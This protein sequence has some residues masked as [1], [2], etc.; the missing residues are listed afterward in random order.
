VANID[1]I[2]PTATVSYSKTTPTN[3]DVVATIA[4]SEDVTVTNNGGSTTLTFSANGSFTFEFVDAAGNTGTATATVANID[5]ENPITSA[6]LNP[7]TP[8]GANGW[9][10]TTVALSLIATDNL[11]GVLRSEYSVNG[12]PWKTYSSAE[13]F[14]DGV[15]TIEYRSSDLVGNVE[16]S[17]SI[18]FKIDTTNPTASIVLDQTTLSPPNHKL[19]TI[20]VAIDSKDAAS[21]IESVVLTSITSNEP[22]NGLG[23]GDTENDI[24]NA[25]FG[26]NDLSFSLRAERSGN[27]TGRVYT[28]TY[29][30]TDKAGNKTIISSEV[31]VPHDASGKKK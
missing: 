8:T 3:Q 26:T 20:N 30:I 23:D 12:G 2:A 22:D 25:D 7:S 29:T 11:S 13:T 21:Q 4:P 18:S 5:K 31:S 15:Y 27:G 16:A 6:M 10:N 1:K 24:Q 17:K 9:F 19:V 28:I 14:T